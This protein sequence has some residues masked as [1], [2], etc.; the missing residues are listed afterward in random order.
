MKQEM[1]DPMMWAAALS[2]A[3]ATGFLLMILGL[4]V[5]VVS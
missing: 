3:F 5:R 4:T 2:I 1:L